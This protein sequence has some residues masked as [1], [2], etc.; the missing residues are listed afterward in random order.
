MFLSD[1]KVEELLSDL[2]RQNNITTVVHEFAH[3]ITY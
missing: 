2:F 3:A 1:L